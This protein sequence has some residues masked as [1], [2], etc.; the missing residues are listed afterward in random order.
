MADTIRIDDA[1]LHGLLAQIEA[2]CAGQGVQ[3][4]ATGGF[5][6]D[7]LS[8]APVHDIDVT[9]AGDPLVIG[10]ALAA[11]LGG[12]FFPLREERKQARILLADRGLHIDLMP[13]RAAEH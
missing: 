10:P 5:L 4:W 12:T 6:R 3:A 8:G 2:V 13:L 7:C 1:Q 9:I 11:T